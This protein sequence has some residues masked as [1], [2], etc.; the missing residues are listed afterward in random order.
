MKNSRVENGTY[1][2]L[3]LNAEPQ[4]PFQDKLHTAR[5]HLI[6]ELVGIPG[7]LDVA[8]GACRGEVPYNTGTSRKSASPEFSKSTVTVTCHIHAS[9]APRPVLTGNG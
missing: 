8:V 1:S 2:G 9:I 7:G 4:G 3:A 5:S 6:K